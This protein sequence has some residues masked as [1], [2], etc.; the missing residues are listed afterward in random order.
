MKVA[1]TLALGAML[2]GSPAL[3]QTKP[4][5]VEAATKATAD[6][7]KPEAAPAA[8]AKPAAATPAAPG[9]ANEAL[10]AAE[11][12]GADVEKKAGEKTD[13]KLDAAEKKVGVP[14]AAGQAKA[15]AAKEK[16]K[17][18]KAKAKGHDKAKDTADKIDAAAP[19]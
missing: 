15:A 2:L 14:G 6:K 16:Q 11:T 4:F 12:K 5:G 7:A 19:K 3:A 10:K 9:R 8:A 13:A 17:A 1:K 18:K